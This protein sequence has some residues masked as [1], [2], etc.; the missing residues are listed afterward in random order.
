MSF[1]NAF[2]RSAFQ[3][4]RSLRT[5]TQTAARRYST[6]PTSGGSGAGLWLG[7]GAAAAAGGGYYLYSKN[8]TPA[9]AGKQAATVGKGGVQVAKAAAGF[10][11]SKEDYQKVYNRIADALEAEGYDGK[12]LTFERVHTILR[13][14]QM[15]AS[16]LCLSGWLGIALGHMIRTPRLV[17]GNEEFLMLKIRMVD[18][19]FFSN[20]ATMRFAPESLHG[21]NNGLNIARAEMEKIKA[22]FPW[23][24]Y[25]DLWTLGGV[26][27]I[28][29][30][31]GPK[32]P[33][34]PGRIDGF[35]KNVTP[36]GR[37]PD[38]SQ[39]Q[40]HLRAVSVETSIYHQ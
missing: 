40:D 26:C 11:P 23:I 18:V 1:T 20:Y 27:A 14:P 29:E 3:A 2:R 25:G 28:Q 4:S 16:V 34:R 9:E 8:L 7:L 39:A 37:L 35:E 36:D 6:A 15:A 17:G 30:M 32:I 13:A 10:T 31:G 21:A 12:C 24:S 19:A 22:E 33:W 38:A 5:N